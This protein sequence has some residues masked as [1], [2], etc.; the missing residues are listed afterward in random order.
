[1]LKKVYEREG[2]IC[3]VTFTI[4]AEEAGD[5][6][7][8]TLVGDFNSWD[9]KAMPMKRNKKGC[10]ELKTDL[11]P[12]REYQFRYLLDGTRWENDWNAD[13]YVP[14]PYGDIENSVVIV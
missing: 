7:S 4:R 11:S 8:A 6:T 13:K 9:S 1:M 2:S 3:S 5:A 14:S 12:G 10:F